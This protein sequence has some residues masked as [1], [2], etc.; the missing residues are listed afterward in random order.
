MIA[1][2]SFSAYY[3]LT[4]MFDFQRVCTITIPSIWK[5]RSFFIIHMTSP[6]D[7]YTWPLHMTLTGDSSTWLLHVASAWSCCS[8]PLLSKFNLRSWVNWT[9]LHSFGKGTNS[10]E[11]WS[12]V[13][14]AHDVS[15]DFFCLHRVSPWST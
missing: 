7:L 12:S 1:F 9:L 10:L 11:R 2:I 5:C 3:Q 13:V 4:S 8:Q 6:L 14:S 15:C